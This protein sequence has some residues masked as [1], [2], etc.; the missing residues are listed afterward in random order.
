MRIAKAVRRLIIWF[1]FGRV[2]EKI[3]ATHEGIACEI[4]YYDKHNQP[5][6]YWAYGCFDPNQP[7]RGR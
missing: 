4:E 2:T 5:I 3:K 1:R 6:G 7:Y